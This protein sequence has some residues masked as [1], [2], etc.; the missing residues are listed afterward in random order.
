MIKST[1]LYRYQ[2]KENTLPSE[3]FINYN[4]NDTKLRKKYFIY[5]SQ[6]NEQLLC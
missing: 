5:Y 1:E 2:R 4:I 3:K 6:I